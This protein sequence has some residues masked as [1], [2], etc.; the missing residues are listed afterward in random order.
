MHLSPAQ[1]KQKFLESELAL[2]V[3]AQLKSMEDDP[4]Y[5]TVSV[6]SPSSSE[7]VSFADKHFLY[8][9]SHPA[10]KPNEYLANLRLKT[11]LRSYK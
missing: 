3:Q 9:C 7:A 6:Y 5:A 4:M 11:K 1:Y 10:V 2:E 8:L